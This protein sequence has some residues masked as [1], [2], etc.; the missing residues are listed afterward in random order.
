MNIIKYRGFRNLV[1]ISIL[2]ILL[3]LSYKL[4]QNRKEEGF[5]NPENDKIVKLT[6]KECEL[7]IA[8]YNEDLSWSKPYAHLRT[9][10]N[11]GKDDLDGEYE[12]I[13]KLPNVGTEIHTMLEHIIRN[14]DNLANNTV[15]S[16]GNIADR[17]CSESIPFIDFFHSDDD[18]IIGYVSAI[19]ESYDW[20]H[21]ETYNGR[22]LEPSPHNLGDFMKE[23]LDIEYKPDMKVIYQSQIAVGRKLIHKHPKQYYVDI[24]EKT[25]LAK[26]TFPEEGHYM[27]RSWYAMFSS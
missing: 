6:K 11:K 8:R 18:K 16:Q 19:Y 20:K 27:E 4:L 26:A 1:I 17:A 24:L 14:Y 13:V 15:F 23:I 21:P 3:L 25:N 10:Y 12:P 22:K 2:I 7:V 5:D 9:V